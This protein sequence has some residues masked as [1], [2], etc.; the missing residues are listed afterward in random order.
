MEL[1]KASSHCMDALPTQSSLIPHLTLS[2]RLSHFLFLQIHCYYSSSILNFFTFSL[3]HFFSSSFFNFVIPTY[4]FFHCSL[5]SSDVERDALLAF[6]RT[7]T[8]QIWI[9]KVRSHIV[10]LSGGNGTVQHREDLERIA[11]S[12]HIIKKFIDDVTLRN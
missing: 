2:K 1:Q 3:L 8:L 5:K 4:S 11:N 7:G 12:V 10:C 6:V 9:E